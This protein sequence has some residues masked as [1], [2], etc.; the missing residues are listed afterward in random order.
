MALYIT[1][2]P[3]KLLA[4]TTYSRWN[5]LH[6]PYIFEFHRKDLV[7][8]NTAIRPAYHATKPTIQ[9][10]GDV[11]SLISVGDSVYLNS[12]LYNDNY[13]VHAIY[14]INPTLSYVVINATYIGV[15]SSGWMNIPSLTN[16]K[17][18]LK[19]Y[20]AVSSELIDTT[21]YKPDS[22]GLAYV[23]VSGI[24]KSRLETKDTNAFINYNQKNNKM[25]GSF[26]LGYGF[27]F[28]NITTTETTDPFIYYWINAA[29]QVDGKT[30]PG[31]G[32][33]GQNMK[34]YVPF[35]QNGSAAK[36]L[37]M[38]DKPTQFAS[39]PFS[40]GFIYSEDFQSVYIER[41]QQN[42]NINGA[43]TSSESDQVLYNS[44]KKYLNDLL[45]ASV[46]TNTTQYDIWLETGAAYTSGGY[47]ISGGLQLGSVS[48]YALPTSGG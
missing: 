30:V 10:T 32:G 33:V 37:T 8:A 41:H 3:E 15:G 26:Y 20:D 29:R 47:V 25:S 12:G 28:S 39:Y 27:S 44:E 24:L 31:Q 4:G 45:P 7:V 34:E 2:R 9:I 38:F 14:V 48:A 22:T 1:R 35:N 21:Y 36:F 43:N 42:K 19:L 13:G 5:A 18:F 46:D 11:T 23:D 6:N 16:F 40:L 17:I